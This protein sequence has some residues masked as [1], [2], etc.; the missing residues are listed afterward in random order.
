MC[1]LEC[2][3]DDFVWFLFLLDLDLFDLPKAKTNPTIWKADLSIEESYDEAINGCN[4]VFHVATP[5]HFESRDPE[6]HLI[7]ISILIEA[8]SSPV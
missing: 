8:K 6:V 5:I 3:I 1:S 2:F 7:D 4:G